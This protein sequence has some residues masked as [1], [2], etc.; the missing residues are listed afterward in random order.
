MRNTIIPSGPGKGF[1]D[2]KKIDENG[3]EYWDARELMPLLGYEKWEKAE[4]VSVGPLELV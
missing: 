3:I 4:E 2:I 1:E